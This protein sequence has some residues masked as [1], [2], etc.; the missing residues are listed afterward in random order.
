MRRDRSQR[1]QQEEKEGRKS[2]MEIGSIGGR[3]WAKLIN[4][5]PFVL[6]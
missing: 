6:L 4:S 3:R 5:G 2:N 1:V